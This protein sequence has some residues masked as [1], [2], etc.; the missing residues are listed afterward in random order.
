MEFQTIDVRM[1]RLIAGSAK[2]FGSG[3][4]SISSGTGGIRSLVIDPREL[5]FLVTGADTREKRSSLRID[6]REVEDYM[7]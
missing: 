4:L 1:E 7:F 6:R 3:Q 2:A 5:V